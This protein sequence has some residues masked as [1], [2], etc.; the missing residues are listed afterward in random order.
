MEKLITIALLLTCLNTFAQ[1]SRKVEKKLRKINSIEQ[2]GKLREKYSNWDI[3]LLE[4]YSDEIDIDEK[5]AIPAKGKLS[6]I[7][8]KKGTYTYKTLEVEIEREF[9]VSYIYLDGSK[10]SMEE[11]DSLRT[12]I[13]N[14]YNAGISFS[15]LAKQYTMDSNSRG[16]DMGWAKEDTI[17]ADFANAVKNHKKGEIFRI[18]VVSKKWYYVTLKTHEDREK[19]KPKLVKIKSRGT[20]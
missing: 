16:G 8:D 10:L 11:I 18:D 1:S 7:T 13:I 12:I 15:E 3:E 5:L 4:V 17:V 9:R 19:R 20:F 6:V 2:L 14:K